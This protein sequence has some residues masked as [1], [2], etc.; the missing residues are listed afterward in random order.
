MA[1]NLR[2]T[3][4]NLRYSWS[5]SKST[6]S[7]ANPVTELPQ[8]IAHL[9]NR[10]ARSIVD[11]GAGRGRNAGLLSKSFKTVL[12][13]EDNANISTLESLVDDLDSGNISVQSWEQYHPDASPKFDAVLICFVIHTIPLSSL[14]KSII[15]TNLNRLRQGGAIVFV[16]PNHDPKYR[17]ALLSDAVK[18]GDGIVRLHKKQRSFSFYRNYSRGI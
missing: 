13:V 1:N 5:P 9:K 11:F 16:T 2:L 3:H 7:A 15:H 12:L 6:P 4:K 14:R 10:G 8:I 18:Y 17:P